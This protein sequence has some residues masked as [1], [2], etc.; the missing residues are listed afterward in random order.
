MSTLGPAE[1]LL[2]ARF[3]PGFV[4]PSGGPLAG[5]LP[6][7]LT[8]FVPLDEDDEVVPAPEVRLA[9]LL[10]LFAQPE[11]EELVLLRLLVGL[12]R[13]F[14]PLEEEELVLPTPPPAEELVLVLFVDIEGL[15]RGYG[16]KR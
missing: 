13:L 3:E 14:A 4:A 11:E 7:L 5:C 9:G 6:L 12:L 16:G 15:R 10:G 1:E 8:V 2:L